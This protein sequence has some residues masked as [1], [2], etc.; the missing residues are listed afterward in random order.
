MA[1]LELATGETVDKENLKMLLVLPMVILD[2]QVIKARV[3]GNLFF[4]L[5]L[6]QK[7]AAGLV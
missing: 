4:P 3:A 1:H 6:N 5:P 7:E 2:C